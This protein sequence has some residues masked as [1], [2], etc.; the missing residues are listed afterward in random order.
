LEQQVI[1]QGLVVH[2][3]VSAFLGRFLADLD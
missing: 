1:S 3:C 2:K